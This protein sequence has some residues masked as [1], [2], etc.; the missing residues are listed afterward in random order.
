MVPIFLKSLLRPLVF[1][2]VI[3]VVLVIVIVF[4]LFI[5]SNHRTAEHFEVHKGA[6]RAAHKGDGGGRRASIS[7]IEEQVFAEGGTV[8]QLRM[9]VARKELLLARDAEQIEQLRKEVEDLKRQLLNQQNGAP[10]DATARAKNVPTQPEVIAAQPADSN[11]VRSA[12]DFVQDALKPTAK[13]VVQPTRLP[14]ET[15]P[16]GV[17]NAAAVSAGGRAEVSAEGSVLI[18]STSSDVEKVQAEAAQAKN[19]ANADAP[20]SF[21][22]P[23]SSAS[24]SSSVQEVPAKKIKGLERASLLTGTPVTDSEGV[25]IVYR[26]SVWEQEWIS[27][28]RRWTDEKAICRVL[29]DADTQNALFLRKYL[30][31]TCTMRFEGSDWCRVDTI[32]D[33]ARLGDR[34]GARYSILYR[35]ISA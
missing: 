7:S 12:T 33:L 27:N 26:S 28:I 32:R 29:T 15:K 24:D 10:N 30:N 17:P 25:Q 23:T 1:S 22:K 9:N 4:R 35:R 31:A 13:A 34:R 14:G 3:V 21:V 19:G 11:V 2:I 20:D 6:A 5:V 8:Q 18:N 16:S